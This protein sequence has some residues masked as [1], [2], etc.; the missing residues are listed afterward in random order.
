[1]LRWSRNELSGSED[2]HDGDGSAATCGR[3]STTRVAK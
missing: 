2:G 3:E 1:V